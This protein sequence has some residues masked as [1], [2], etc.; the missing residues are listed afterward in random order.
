MLL[1]RIS[2]VIRETTMTRIK[3]MSLLP[4]FCL[5]GT[6]ALAQDVE[7]PESYTY[8]TYLKCDTSNEAAV[9]EYVAK[10]EVPVLD[11]LSMT[12]S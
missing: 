4:G 6:Y 12:G 11:N 10:Y 7:A 9:D 1:I 2:R 5:L 3:I 8:A